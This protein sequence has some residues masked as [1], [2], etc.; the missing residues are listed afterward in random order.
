MTHPLDRL[1]PAARAWFQGAFEGPTPV[2][3]KGWTPIL[4]G[5]HTLML[6]PTGSGKTLAAFL[7][8]LDRLSRRPADDPPG[9]RILYL[10]PL[11]ALAYD[12]ERNLRAPLLGLQRAAERL[13]VPVTPVRVGVRTGD[14]PMRDR[15][16][17]SRHPPDLLVTTPESL[18]LMLGSS[19][20]EQ[21]RHV[22]AVIVDEIH[23]MAGT[24]RGV[25]LSLSLERLERW[26]GR[27]IQRI[28][29]SATQRPL[30][31]IARF[32][33]GD[34]PVEIVDASERPRLDV[35]IVVPLDDLDTPTSKVVGDKPTPN[36][37][38][39]AI[40]PRLLEL[41]R[42][43]R[44]TLLFVNS[45]ILCERLAHALNE[46]AGE[47][48]V[49][50][51]HGSIARAQR[52]EIED[53]LKQGRLRA[54]VA[55]SSLELGIDM[56]AVDLVVQIG[57]PG[58]V[59]RGLQRVGRAGHGVG[60]TSVGRIF[61]KFKGDLLEAAVVARHM[62]D[63]SIETTRIPRNCL[64]VL[65]QHIVSMTAVEPWSVAD[66]GALVR[67]AAPYQ[68]LGP[69][70]LASVLDLLSGRWP[71][72][73]F[74][75]LR[76]RVTW[77]RVAD[78]V[79]ARKGSGAIALVNAG[80][81][82][83]RGLYGVHVG[84][85]GP[86]VGELDEE[87]VY[88]SRRGDVIV[89]GASSWRIDEI[90]RDKVLVRPAPGEPGR[91]PFWRGDSIGRP[92]DLGRAVGAF[93]REIAAREPDDAAAFVRAEAPVDVLS[94]KNLVR[95][96]QDQRLATGEVPSDRCVV[97]ER[98]RDEL[99]DWRVC[100]LS[101]FGARV[102][103]PWALALEARLGGEAGF[104]VQ[105]MATDDGIV[106][107]FADVEDLP[108]NDWLFPDP[109][110]VEDQ[111]VTQLRH[112]GQFAGRFREN[113]GRALLLPR[114]SPTARRPLWQQRLKAQNLLAATSAWPSFPI[115]LETY[116]ECLQDVFDVPS[117]T[118]VL[119]GVRSREIRVVEAET[120]SASP[121]ARSLVFAYVA[122]HLY[123]GDAPLAERR[124]LALGLDREL[125]RELL[126]QETL[127]DL[128]DADV[129]RAVGDELQALDPDRKA[130][131]PDAL[132]DLLRR[133]GDLDD[134]E[135]AA[136]CDGDVAA[137]LTEL[138]AARRVLKVR[139]VGSPRWIAVEDA[140]RYAE[141][142]GVV[143]PSGIPAAFLDAGPSPLEA[144]IAR[145]ARTHPPFAT[146]EVASRFGL[147]D[148]Q[149][150]PILRAMVTAGKLLEA[151]LTPGRTGL[152]WCDVD[153]LRRL[154]RRSL[155][156]HRAEIEPVAP[157]VYARFLLGWHGVGGKRGGPSAVREA[158][159][160]L[161][162]RALP[163]STLEAEILPNRVPDYRPGMLDELGAM[164]EIVW[165]GRGAT[166]PHDGRV[167][168]VA[169]ERV[170]LLCD[171]PE[172][173][174]DPTPLHAAILRHLTER[175]AS[176]LTSIAHT[177]G[178]VVGEELVEALWDLVWSGHVTNDTFLPLRALAGPKRK[179]PSVG[180]RWSLV[181]ELFTP[182][183]PTARAFAR[184]QV[185]LAR[186]GVVSSGVADV[187]ELPG[188]Y[189]AVYPVLRAMEDSGQARRGWFVDGLDG[190]QFAEPG[191]VDRLRAHRED[192]PEAR[193][194][195]ALDPA[196][197]Y[198]GVLPWRAGDT[199]GLRRV[200][201]AKVILV[202]GRPALYVHASGRA[203]STLDAF[204]D[205]A[206]ADAAIS[207][208]CRG[209]YR[210]VRVATIDGADARDSA[211]AARL[212]AAGFGDDAKGL[213]RVID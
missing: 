9:V 200:P 141:A 132:T 118:T 188:G 65:A 67:K 53:L 121:F 41:V 146:S 58:S 178:V 36:G 35:E 30:E 18:F 11:K 88:E 195:S 115:V 194:V 170:S 3:E 147:R 164:G 70:S 29:L 131:H 159:Q 209:R 22:D 73:G 98:F 172:P 75:D 212:R 61:P 97:V 210:T 72:D 39:G 196:N 104:E 205:D 199:A 43:H 79:V 24:K 157:E 25:H 44:T 42:S 32:L 130:R 192:A 77:D 99:G 160:R 60:Q 155:A 15:R 103:T 135:L 163:W 59:A 166:G 138:S 16:E 185:L 100:I 55:T 62:R 68:T 117:L 82:P 38:W 80:T 201:G 191:V 8:G 89:L 49:R 90:T 148:A 197:P 150:T 143:L 6:A 127:R 14:T 151:E 113:A 122:E 211:H 168:L 95:Y 184:A 94:A 165:L 156:A 183:T 149:V 116:R 145:W 189:S 213:V 28:G 92:Y 112:S 84:A 120:P 13:A 85:D 128:L 125:L 83:D 76:P 202:G 124:A 17:M 96:V 7:V 137:W 158:V 45:R 20:R 5:K 204:A 64:D 2:Q 106:L 69:A 52:E 174:A 47:D 21:L 161:E 12:V 190:A 86:R 107:R 105:A 31:E 91:L 171:P 162:G 10:S 144:L 110:E 51:H 198:G 208:L 71:S 154:R 93:V 176:F 173:L 180:G 111:V 33:G 57:S 102:H 153:V 56:G 167:V 23:A 74:A 133:V 46:L 4:D 123:N 78:T 40:H 126:G 186:H 142:L 87:M 50:A 169:R 136:R 109:D 27:P 48:L 63:A 119:T 26:V 129:I 34:R 179:G 175:G 66:L 114:K 19:Q 134:D 203:L 193:T 206:V 182:T 139:I 177:A 101:P 181:S 54:L 81:I 108:P 1:G 140:G 152:E 187:E 207:E 37:A